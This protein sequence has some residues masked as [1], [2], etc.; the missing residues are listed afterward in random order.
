M[1]LHHLH[2]YDMGAQLMI[3]NYEN[4]VVMVL[5]SLSLSPYSMDQPM[6]VTHLAVVWQ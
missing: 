2:S 6:G 1:I 3:N 5:S 4:F